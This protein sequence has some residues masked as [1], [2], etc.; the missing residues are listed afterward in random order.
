MS[1]LP[2]FPLNLVLLPYEY[3]PL[4]IF[5]PRYKNMIRNAIED[6]LPFGIILSEGE[7]VYSK[8]VKVEVNK[9]YKEYQNGEYDIL[10]KG[11]DLFNVIKTKVQGE[12][13]I[14]EIEYLPIQVKSEN[15][16]FKEF[17]NLYLKILLKLGVDKD[18]NIHMDK[19]ISYEFLQGMQL[20]IS[21]KKNLI[22]LNEETERL[23]FITKI[24]NE[25]LQS[26]FNI[27]SKD[28]PKA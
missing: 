9:V 27:P 5:E 20:P 21:I 6:E 12:T 13:V 10:V 28:I 23:V 3:L 19:Q 22:S 1:K 16:Q 26:D 18:L 24:F 11:Q 17:Q 4:H 14:G 15:S 25:I 8:G 2:L 7:G